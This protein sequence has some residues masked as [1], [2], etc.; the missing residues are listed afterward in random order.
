MEEV[1]EEEDFG[2]QYPAELYTSR[3]NEPHKEMIQEDL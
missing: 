1:L 3:P 2:P